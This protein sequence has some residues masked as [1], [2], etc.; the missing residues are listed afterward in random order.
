[1]EKNDGKFAQIWAVTKIFSF[2]VFNEKCDDSKIVLETCSFWSR[3]A[4]LS[5]TWRL[6]E[7]VVEVL[8]VEIFSQLDFEY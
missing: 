6:T 8:G 2:F 5:C 3:I 7:G 1:M 4:Y